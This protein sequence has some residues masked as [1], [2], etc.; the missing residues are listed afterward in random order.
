[1]RKKKVFLIGIAVISIIILGIFGIINTLFYSMSR[2]P[3]G[4]FLT[5]STSE[6]GAYTI[7][8]YLC[9]GGATV[10]YAIRGEVITNDKGHKRK[11]IYWDYKID[12][13]DI[14][15]EDNDTVIINGHKIN[16]PNGKYDW[17]KDKK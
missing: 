6:N 3:N 2:L 17:R 15:W 12:K 1:M 14:S 16:L 11:N 8:A 4:E 13:A 10:S 5:E 7:K 9:N